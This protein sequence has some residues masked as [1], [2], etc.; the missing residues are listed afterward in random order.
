MPDVT[1]RMLSLLASLQTGRSFGGGELAA[2]LGVSPRTLRRDVDRLREYGYPVETRPGPGGHYRLTAGAVMPPLMLEDD[3]AIAVL[4]GL[5][6]L[7]ATG[8]ADEGSV[9][10][11][12]TRAYGKVEQ[13]LPKR[14]RHRI[15]RVRSSLETSEVRAPSTSA[16]DLGELADAIA[17]RQ[18][19]A[20]DYE[21]K[22][23]TASSRRVEPYR[24]VHHLQRW[25]LLGWDLDRGDWR[26]FRT[27]RLS[28]LRLSTSRFEPRPAP[29]AV[30]YLIEGIGKDRQ[31][32]VF[33]IEGPPGP[34]AEAFRHDTVELS[35]LDDGRTRVA[36]RLDTW[37]WP[38]VTLAFLDADFTIEAPDAF[39]EGFSRFAER[40]RAAVHN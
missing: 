17:A 33:V 21:R 12:A 18:V 13:Y 15:A 9:D 10:E 23:G 31:P 6:A 34:V 22:D 27:D 29:P 28:G 38:L 5:A 35:A 1:R 32:V 36:L 30:D 26:V 2:R 25:F 3:E 14:L 40:L 39:R 7:A 20:F 19:V 16:G 8:S 24:Q 11:A 37:Q 4:L